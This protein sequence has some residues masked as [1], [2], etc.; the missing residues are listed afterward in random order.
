M[1]SVNKILELRFWGVRGSIAAPGSHTV[2]VGGNTTCLSLQVG[3]ELLIF[4]AGTGIRNLGNFLQEER[5]TGC[6]GHIFFT[7]YHWD[8][9]QGLPFFA[10][11]RSDKYQFHLYGE[12]KEGAD[13]KAILDTQMQ[14]PY[15]PVP[16]P[17]L[18]ALEEF[19]ALT[20]DD[21]I[22]LDNGACVRTGRLNHPNGAIGYRVE[23]GSQVICIVTDHEHPEEGLDPNVVSF[24]E[25]ADVLVHDAQYHPDE[26]AGPKKGWGHSSWEEAALTAKE[27]RVGR[28][29]LSHHDPDR[30]DAE[31]YE[32][33]SQARKLFPDTD[34]ATETTVALFDS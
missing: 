34:A 19:T 20:E 3:D 14:S 18:D 2:A 29:F 21:T 9:I 12:R 7:H 28:L 24:V 33:T 15:S 6:H 26:K 5:R 10:P 11:G 16:F 1:N 23:Y 27:A 8:H 32:I 17:E 30:S 25:G 22:E 13:L 4:D 31:V